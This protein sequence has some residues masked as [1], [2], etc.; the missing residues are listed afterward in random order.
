[1]SQQTKFFSYA[2][3]LVL[4]MCLPYGGSL[5]AAIVV[6]YALEEIVFQ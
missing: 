1:M 5:I 2:S 6:C 3:I 4:G